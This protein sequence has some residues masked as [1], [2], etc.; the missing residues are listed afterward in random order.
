MGALVEV[1]G[2]LVDVIGALVDGT[3]ALVDV[4]G[5]LVDVMD[6]LM[7][8]MGIR[9][10]YSASEIII[11]FTAELYFWRGL[12]HTKVFQLKRILRPRQELDKGTI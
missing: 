11:I 8:V 4:M 12:F 2:A 7:D 1:V 5:T 3:G 6:A 9:H 10:A